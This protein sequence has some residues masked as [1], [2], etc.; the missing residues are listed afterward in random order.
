MDLL[1]R[2][3]AHDAWTTALLIECAR[4]LDDSQLDRALDIGPGTVRNTLA[5]VVRNTEVWA[6]LM[7][8]DAVPPALGDRPSLGEI[9]SRHLKASAS[10]ARLARRIADEG[11][12]DDRWLDTLDDPPAE[13]TF[14]GAIAHVLTHSMH[15]RAQL[16]N[17]YRRLGLRELPE[18]DVLTWEQAASG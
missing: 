7:S 5:H 8:G 18:G 17:M 9:E 3:L 15:H 10:L 6:A 16:L 14:G 4:E 11:A 2:L 13:K 12:W 1:D